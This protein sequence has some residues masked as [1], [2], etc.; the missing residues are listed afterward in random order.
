MK[1]AACWLALVANHALD[2]DDDLFVVHR[3]GTQ[4]LVSADHAAVAC[5][6]A[7]RALGRQI[8]WPVSFQTD[9]LERAL[10]REIV[11]LSFTR[12]GPRSVLR[13]LAAAAGADV[14]F[15]DGT[16][17]T[18]APR[19]CRV[20]VVASADARSKD[21]RA[22]LRA[23][24]IEC[25]RT[26]LDEGAGRD[27]G[28]ASVGA[29]LNMARL[30][31]EQGA[32]E[33]AARAW[34]SVASDD[35]AAAHAP[36]AMLQVAQALHELGGQHRREAEHWARELAELPPT[37]PESAAAAV[38]LGEILIAARRPRE[39]VKYLT[40]AYVRLVGTPQVVESYLTIARAHFELE[41]PA[42]ALAVLRTLTA[43][44]APATLADRQVRDLLFVE[45]WARSASGD[46]RAAVGPLQLFVGSSDRVDARTQVAWTALA[47][48]LLGVGE[49]VDARLAARKALA[50][51]ERS[52]TAPRWRTA[53]RIVSAKTEL[54][55]GATDGLI[56]ELDAAARRVAEQDAE[57]VLFVVGEL[58][59]RLRFQ[60]AIDLTDLVVAKRGDVGD[61]ARVLR[62]RALWR[63]AAE[64]GT[65]EAFP[66]LAREVARGIAAPAR[67]REVATMLGDAFARLGRLDE[68][69]D[70]YAGV[71]R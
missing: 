8:G 16:A 48:A 26:F 46:A 39:C 4:L 10:A 29:R 37:V 63:R 32:L 36:A 5:D 61:R 57:F 56:E 44:H 53:A 21:G 34:A 41:E 68:A 12:Q 42:A 71:V 65:L 27:A 28:D 43:A 35:A 11:D 23:R 69:A 52:D 3:D 59:E 62:I 40:N 49:F 25:Y 55:I 13:L 22:R 50:L 6:R 38:L 7:L 18:S 51:A 70:A 60:K 19:D 66:S 15:D 45:G 58:T 14:V 31:T 2:P 64:Q 47:D 17:T 67:Q 20:V 24:A 9:E 33:E 30:L 1:L 54:A